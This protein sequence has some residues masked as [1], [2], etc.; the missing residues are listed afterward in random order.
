MNIEQAEDTHI[1][2]TARGKVSLVIPVYN[3]GEG[4][5][6]LREALLPLLDNA[7]TLLPDGRRVRP[8]DWEVLLVNDGSRD[9]CIMPGYRTVS[10]KH[11][12][13]PTNSLV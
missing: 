3:E 4:L 13:L 11:M 10:Y 1:R 5:Q 8:Y 2:A 7:M 6:R 12:T 9:N